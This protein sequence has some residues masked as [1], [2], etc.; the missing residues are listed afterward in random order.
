MRGGCLGFRLQ[1]TSDFDP[2][3]TSCRVP[4]GSIGR[5]SSSICSAAWRPDL[6]SILFKS[7]GGLNSCELCCCTGGLCTRLVT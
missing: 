2:K 5:V 3:Q 7:R 4:A 1:R 6:R